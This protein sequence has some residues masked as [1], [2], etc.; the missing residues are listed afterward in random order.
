MNNLSCEVWTC[1]ACTVEIIINK[2]LRNVKGNE[3]Q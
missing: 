3:I 1:S 2:P